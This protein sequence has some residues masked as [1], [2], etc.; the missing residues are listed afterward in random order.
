VNNL[1]LHPAQVEGRRIDV[2]V[3]YTVIEVKKVRRA[4]MSGNAGLA[5]RARSW[6]PYAELSTASHP[7]PI[8]P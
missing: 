5:A 7:R 2:K 8:S 6:R 4:G 3:G 1:V